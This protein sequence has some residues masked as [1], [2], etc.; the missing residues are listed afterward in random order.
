MASEGLEEK[1]EKENLFAKEA[2]G[3]RYLAIEVD[4]TY[5]QCDGRN[6]YR[7]KEVYLSESKWLCFWWKIALPIFPICP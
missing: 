1:I 7:V 2:S 6:L 3:R 5:R 4:E